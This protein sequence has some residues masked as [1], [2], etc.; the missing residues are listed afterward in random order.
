MLLRHAMARV[1][2]RNDVRRPT[3]RKLG[4]RATGQNRDFRSSLVPERR[5]VNIFHSL[6]QTIAGA[7]RNVV[8][9]ERI[10]RFVT[11][12]VNCPSSTLIGDNNKTE[13]NRFVFVLE[14]IL[15]V[16]SNT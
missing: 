10:T 15:T 14:I 8:I 3:G 11:I 2:T 12:V 4:N 1:C 6:S 16:V 13:R 5:R 9:V 7:E